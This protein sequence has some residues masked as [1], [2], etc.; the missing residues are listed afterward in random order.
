MLA[1]VAEVDKA[2][3]TVQ[4]MLPANFPPHVWDKVS[5]GVRRHARQFVRETDM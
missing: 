5:A 4:A 1:M 3:N 2:L